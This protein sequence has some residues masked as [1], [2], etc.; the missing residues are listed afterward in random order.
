MTNTRTED[1]RKVV[2]TAMGQAR[3]PLL[4]VLGAGNMAG[5]AVADAVSK[6]RTRVGS[7]SEVAKK[8]I[9]ELPAELENLRERLGPSGLRKAVDDYGDAAVKLYH[10]LADT[11]EQTWTGTVEPQM[12]RGVEQFEEALRTAGQRVDGMTTDAR[13]RMDEVIGLVTRRAG[14]TDEEAGS[15]GST[16]TAAPSGDKPGPVKATA[17]RVPAE[18]EADRTRSAESASTPTAKARSARKKAAKP[19]TSTTAAGRAP[20]TARENGEGSSAEKS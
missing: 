15:T 16:G 17:A 12:K 10:R 14:E 19:E 2:N 18:P 1:V 13:Q 5:Q 3:T 7:S 9:E 4:A 11:G 20:R 6:A 8:N